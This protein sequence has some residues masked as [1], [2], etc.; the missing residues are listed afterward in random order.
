MFG[1]FTS[2][3]TFHT[4]APFE[5]LENAHS[6]QVLASDAKRTRPIRDFLE[7]NFSIFCNERIG[8]SETR[9]PFSCSLEI[10]N[11][12]AQNLVQEE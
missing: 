12:A 8:W 6:T 10:Y 11:A 5:F 3:H 7:M 4:N 2:I 9:N 1:A